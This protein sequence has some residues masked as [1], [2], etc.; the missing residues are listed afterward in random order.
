MPDEDFITVEMLERIL[1]EGELHPARDGYLNQVR[2]GS[3]YYDATEKWWIPV[4]E[5][6]DMQVPEEQPTSREN[7][8]YDT[9]NEVN[10]LLLK[11]RPTVRTH[12]VGHPE[13]SDLSD[14]MDRVLLAAWKNS[15]TRH[16]IRSMQKESA[17]CG[18]SVGKVGWNAGSKRTGDGEVMI[19]K[20]APSM[21]ILDP[22]A[23]NALRATDCRYI[24]DITKQTPEAIW[25]RY[26][27]EGAAALGL[28]DVRGRKGSFSSFLKLLERKVIGMVKGESSDE[29]EKVDRRVTVY[30]FW[31]FPV[32]GRESELAIGEMVK[33]A[34]YPY[35]VVATM[36]NREIVRVMANPFAKRKQVMTGE[37]IEAG[38]ETVEVGHKLHPFVLLYWSREADSEGQNGIY[39]CKGM[40]QQQL[41]LQF[42][43]NRLSR[44]IM[45]NCTTT[46]NPGLDVIE[47]A[48]EIP[49]TKITMP[50]GGIL[51]INPKYVGRIDDVLRWHD[52]T[53]LP[54][55]VY[56]F[57]MDK[58]EGIKASG[59]LKPGMVGLAPTGTSHTPEG[60]IFGVQQASFS[61][62]WTPT[63]ELDAALKDVAS[64]YLGLI[65]QYYKPGR[66]IDVSGRGESHYIEFQSKHIATQFSLEVVSGT[67]TPLYD[68][69]KDTKLGVIKEIV[70]AAL[71]TQNPD[72]LQSTLIYLVE[73][74]YPPAY[75][76]V[77]LLE[78]VIQRLGQE[79]AELQQLGATGLEMAGQGGMFQAQ[80]G[81]GASPAEPAVAGEEEGLRALAEELGVSEEEIIRVLSG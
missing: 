50:P 56:R 36:I 45:Q 25:Y 39:S 57:M 79:Q 26:G 63:D 19:V 14:D 78:R 28:R 64:R 34:K 3:L 76:W 65:Q 81:A 58:R 17:I 8:I 16:V 49:S 10:S 30:E 52:G 42:D 4:D 67:T 23:S 2:R 69:Q 62:M 38:K 46:A 70:D 77:Q 66:W 5:F 61:R 60:T 71:A 15:Y 29:E 31:L 40:V 80:A 7:I 6:E 43:L 51:R 44:N 72:I 9:V 13:L 11:N 55:Y 27:E 20:R 18:L 73:L 74:D 24:V 1:D 33:E 54:E 21:C 48:L 53:Q 32:P 41:P 22:C 37:G 47:D 59:G 75:S 35:G 68:V 12:P